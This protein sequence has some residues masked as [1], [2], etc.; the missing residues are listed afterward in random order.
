[1]G[2][3]TPLY[4]SHQKMGARIVPFGGWDMP[5]HY[6]SQLDE[7]YQVRQ[8]AGMFDVSHMCVV[9]LKGAGVRPFLQRLLA[10][11]VARL[12]RPGKALYS[13]ML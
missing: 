5:L 8:D 10:N 6:G 11:D 9:D 2:K 3:Q 4:Q 1:M 12:Q 7:H 13:C